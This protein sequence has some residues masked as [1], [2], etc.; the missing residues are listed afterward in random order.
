MN[1]QQN[2]WKQAVIDE[3]VIAHILNYSNESDPRKAIRDLIDWHCQ[4][5]LDPQVSSEAAELVKQAKLEGGREALLEAAIAA[6]DDGRG[7]LT[8]YQLRRMAEERK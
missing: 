2:P 8:G 4:V 3:L 6:D 5:V 1:E 7:N